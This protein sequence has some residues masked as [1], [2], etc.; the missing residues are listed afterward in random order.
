VTASLHIGILGAAW[1]ADEGTVDA[2]WNIAALQAGKHVLS[3]KPLTSNA[4]QAR[5]VQTAAQASSGRIAEGFHYLHHP[6]NTPASSAR[7][8]V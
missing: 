4:E 7:R 3:E 1:I 8:A 5:A 6:V 2:R